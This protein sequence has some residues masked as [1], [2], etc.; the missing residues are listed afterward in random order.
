MMRNV[1]GTFYEK[2]LLRETTGNTL[3]P[4][5]FELT[6]L[7]V[8]NCRFQVGDRILDVGCGWGATVDRLRSLYQLEA[9]GID[10]SQRLLVWGREAYPGLPISQGRGEDIPFEANSLDGVFLECSLS[11]M[12]DINKVLSEIQRVLKVDGRLVIHDVYA[13][14]PRG[15]P[16]LQALRMD[17]CIRS[18]LIKEE[19]EN[20]LQSRG[21]RISQWQDHSALL[22]QLTME[23]IMTHGSMS[24]FWLKSADCSADPAEVQAALKKAKVG[25]FQLI[26]QKEGREEAEH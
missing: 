6:D 9:Y 21:L 11:L 23:L 13:R 3:R 20:C 10:P 4:G 24:A 2:N 17:S 5:G 19:L 1:K 16:D 18:A 7:A 26:A 25:Y 8:G 12:L 22:I 15:V 14:D